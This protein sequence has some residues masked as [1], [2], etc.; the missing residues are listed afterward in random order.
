L[1]LSSIKNIEWHSM[2]QFI[3]IGFELNGIQT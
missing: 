1:K 3:G 2:Q